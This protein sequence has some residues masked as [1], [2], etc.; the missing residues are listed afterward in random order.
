MKKNILIGV[1]SGIAAYKVLDLIKSLKNEGYEENEFHSV[2]SN[3]KEVY[4]IKPRRGEGKQHG[5]LTYEI[6]DY[7]SKFTDKIEL[8]QTRKPDI[9]FELNNKKYAIE[10]E[11]G[12]LYTYIDL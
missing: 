11:T 6:A 12:K 5:F 1:T 2:L 9:V 8:F 4:M 7:I 10:V 3:K